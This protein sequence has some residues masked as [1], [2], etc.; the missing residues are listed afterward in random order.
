MYANNMPTIVY[1]RGDGSKFTCDN[2][3]DVQPTSNKLQFKFYENPDLS[4]RNSEEEVFVLEDTILKNGEELS[5][6]SE[7]LEMS[8]TINLETGLESYIIYRKTTNSE[9][10]QFRPGAP[11]IEFGYFY[12]GGDF[13]IA[14]NWYHGDNGQSLFVPGSA[15]TKYLNNICGWSNVA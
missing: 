14:G 15:A 9:D 6:I 13:W 7:D 8:R 12:N 4:S 2:E 11:R 3:N 10:A 1:Q 5:I